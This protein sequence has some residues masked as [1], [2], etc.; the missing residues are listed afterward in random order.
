MS[1][2]FKLVFTREAREVLEDLTSPQYAV[3]LKKVRKALGQLERDPR[4]PALNSHKYSSLHGSAGEEVWDS[5]VENHTP[6]AWR[7]FW[8]YG[9]SEDT[10]TILT[11]GPHP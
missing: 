4:Y 3:K 2:P 1:G 9:P 6:G 8:H 7:I 5:Y 11:L 10:I